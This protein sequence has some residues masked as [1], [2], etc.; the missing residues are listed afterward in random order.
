MTG[1]YL[2]AGIRRVFACAVDWPGWCRSGRGEEQALAA[3]A[4]TASRYAVVAALAGV[5]FDPASEVDCIEVAEWV[6]GG[7]TTDFGALDVAPALDSEP[8]TH[9]TTPGKSRTRPP[10]GSGGRPRTSRAT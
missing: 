9:S 2:E 3:L 1:V 8:G 6:T 5:A 7:A 10:G 4:I